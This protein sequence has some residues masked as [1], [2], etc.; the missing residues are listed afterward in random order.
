MA[1]RLRLQPGGGLAAVVTEA[2]EPGDRLFHP[3]SGRAM[4]IERVLADRLVV[5]RG[6]RRFSVMRS[7]IGV[8]LTLMKD[9]DPIDRVNVGNLLFH[10]GTG[11]LARVAAV[12]EQDWIVTRGYDETFSIEK[13]WLDISV[14]VVPWKTA[15][16][17]F[18][19][20]GHSHFQTSWAP[21]PHQLNPPSP[22]TERRSRPWQPSVHRAKLAPK[23]MWLREDL[24]E[25]LLGISIFDFRL[26]AAWDASPDILAGIENQFHLRAC[27][28]GAKRRH[29]LLPFL[30]AEGCTSKDKT[31]QQR[32]IERHAGLVARRYRKGR[33]REAWARVKAREAGA[34]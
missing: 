17:E 34:P 5:F 11:R 26:Q 9:P 4:T 32:Y 14:K 23:R 30:H 27:E 33:I 24:P 21:T 3:A 10:I 6:R 7:W 13:A 29:P 20:Q 22:P 19:K 12:R 28:C 18:W 15:P 8:S 16:A 31:P 25:T 1:R 2:I